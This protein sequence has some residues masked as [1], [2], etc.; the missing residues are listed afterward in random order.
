MFISFVYSMFEHIYFIQV[1]LNYNFWL[2]PKLDNLCDDRGR[3]VDANIQ[4]AIAFAKLMVKDRG[5]SMCWLGW[6]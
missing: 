6:S 2:G 3:I 5:V 1:S 4:H